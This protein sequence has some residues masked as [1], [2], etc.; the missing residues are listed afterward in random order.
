MEISEFIR[1]KAGEHSI[2]FSTVKGQTCNYVPH[3][4]LEGPFLIA[5]FS[6]NPCNSPLHPA[7]DAA[8]LEIVPDKEVLSVQEAYT[9]NS[10][11]FG[12]GEWSRSK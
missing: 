6:Q 7:V 10:E 5:P 1:D 4:E 12:C 3:S 8:G 9:P 11:C 2:Y